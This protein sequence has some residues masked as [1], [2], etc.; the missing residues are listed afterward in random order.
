MERDDTTLNATFCLSG[1]ISIPVADFVVDSFAI[2]S[3]TDIAPY[4]TRG[5]VGSNYSDL[6]TY[7]QVKTIVSFYGKWNGIYEPFVSSV[8][9][10]QV[11]LT[12]FPRGTFI[13][14]I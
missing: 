14:T 9:L 8:G 3:S 1:G 2:A 12:D 6:T 7:F 4:P 11:P 13:A 10:L 5:S